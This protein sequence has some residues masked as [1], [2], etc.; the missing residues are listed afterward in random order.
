MHLLQMLALMSAFLP[1]TPRLR[2]KKA[3]SHTGGYRVNPLSN[4]KKEAFGRKQGSVD[5]LLAADIPVYRE[6]GK[7]KKLV[8]LP[9]GLDGSCAF[10]LDLHHT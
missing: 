9:T 5:A 3:V 8:L 2:F 6:Y 1:V 4:K 10:N 7:C